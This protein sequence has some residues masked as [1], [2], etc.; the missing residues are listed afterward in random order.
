MNVQQQESPQC[1]P[2]TSAKNVS[3]VGA[4]IVTKVP[5]LWDIV[6]RA[7]VHAESVGSWE[8]FILSAQFCC[9]PKTVLKD[10]VY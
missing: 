2:E 8:L 5:L 1:R 4:S 7:V 10:K 3:N 6:S 9:E